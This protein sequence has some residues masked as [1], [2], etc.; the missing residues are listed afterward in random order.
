M[1][2]A[3]VRASRAAGRAGLITLRSYTSHTSACLPWE[4]HQH[5]QGQVSPVMA[6][7]ARGDGKQSSPHLE[8]SNH[9]QYFALILYRKAWPTPHHPWQSC[10][11]LDRPARDSWEWEFGRSRRAR[12]PAVCPKR[13]SF[14]CLE[15]NG[16]SAAE[17]PCFVY[18][19]N[20]S[21]STP[22]SSSSC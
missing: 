22:S 2:A 16:S 15:K 9:S 10:S 8:S 5:L 17:M 3:P 12:A 4:P 18:I 7:R 14:C 11:S 21:S 19:C 13:V 1:G 20:E 6:P